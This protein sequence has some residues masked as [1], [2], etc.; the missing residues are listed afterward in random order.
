MGAAQTKEKADC[1]QFA[2]D[3]VWVNRQIM[4]N[5]TWL[6]MSHYLSK[7]GMSTKIG[8]E[9]RVRY[10]RIIEFSDRLLSQFIAKMEAD[11]LDETQKASFFMSALER[12]QEGGAMSLQTLKEA[13]QILISTAIDTTSTILMPT[14]LHLAIEQDVQQR[15]ADELQGHVSVAGG[16]TEGMLAGRETGL[17]YLNAVI[18]E[19]HRVRPGL[20]PWVH[21]KSAP[22]DLRIHGHTAPGETM[23]TLDTYSI[24]NDPDHVPDADKFI[25]ERWLADAVEARKGTPSEVIDHVLLR[26]PFSHGARQCPASRVRVLRCNVL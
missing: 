6:I 25:P 16:I 12:D 7:M 15:L 20:G 17:A 19:N 2:D 14:L 18:R 26:S 11:E 22:M 3:L 21:F 9:W 8:N 13:G 4:D 23:V 24:Q 10:D 1:F 5:S